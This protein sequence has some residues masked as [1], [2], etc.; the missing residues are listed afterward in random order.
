MSD[1]YWEQQNAIFRADNERQERLRDLILK[2]RF[3]DRFHA[4]A[5][6]FIK[7]DDPR[8]AGGVD[9][10]ASG[11][12]IDEKIVQWPHNEDGTPKAE[13]YSAFALETMS[14]TVPGRERYGWMK[15]NIVDFLLY[16]FTDLHEQRLDCYLI[17]FPPLQQ[18]FYAEDHKQWPRWC[19]RQ[20][21]ETE[22]RIVPITQVCD[23]VQYH[24]MVF[25]KPAHDP[26]FQNLPYITDDIRCL[27]SEDEKFARH[28]QEIRENAL[29]FNQRLR[30]GMSPI[31][32]GKLPLPWMNRHGLDRLI[33]MQTMAR[34]KQN[35][36][37]PY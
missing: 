6:E 20:V 2:P 13:P 22:C 1:D 19:S 9:T 11:K 15:T 21:N 37:V 29:L 17:D 28:C 24:Y 31:E 14:C 27:W 18:W 34:T 33:E 36:N 30:N 3:Y 35:K 25:L 23:A 12:T 4:N 7:H 10:I 8:A 16:C 32:A 26:D 5:Y